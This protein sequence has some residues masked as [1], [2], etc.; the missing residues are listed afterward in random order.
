MELSICIVTR[1][2][3][4]HLKALLE[5]IRETVSLE[6]EVIIVDEASEDD[7]AKM[8]VGQAASYAMHVQ[9]RRNDEPVYFV[10]ACNQSYEGSKGKYIL[11]TNPDIVLHDGAVNFMY[12]YMEDNPDV[13]LVCPKLVYPDGS[14][15]VAIGGFPTKEWFTHEVRGKNAQ[16]PNNAV[17]RK[18]MYTGD[19]WDP[20]VIQEPDIVAGSC[21]LMRPE[22]MEDVGWLDEGFTQFWSIY[23]LCKNLQDAGWRTVYLPRASVTHARGEGGSQ[24]I[25]DPGSI[26]FQDMLYL[27][28][29]HYGKEFASTLQ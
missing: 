28:K 6:H 8:I 21:L 24:E 22:A 10:R 25:K 4:G 16:N 23:D 19:R 11:H 2:A 20:N 5:S 27:A 18:V 26:G 29:K 3:E 14:L 17:N 9:Y 7:T 1:N 13:A 12:H 15:Q